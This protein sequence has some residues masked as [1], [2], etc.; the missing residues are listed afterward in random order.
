[1]DMIPM[2]FRTVVDNSCDLI[3]AFDEQIKCLYINR[4][5]EK[6]TGMQ[7]HDL[8]DKTLKE[9]G[10]PIHACTFLEEQI[11][12]AF[13]TGKDTEHEILMDFPIGFTHRKWLWCLIPE[14][15]SDGEILCVFLI[16]RD[17]TEKK[18]PIADSSL[19]TSR[20]YVLFENSMDMIFET[21]KNGAITY[22]SHH[23]QKYGFKEEELLSTNIFELFIPEDRDHASREYLRLQTSE[24]MATMTMRLRDKNGKL[25]WFECRCS[26]QE[27]ANSA[28]IGISGILKDITEHMEKE[29]VIRI[30]EAVSITA[31][32][33]LQIGVSSENFKE[34][35]EQLGR[36]TNVSRVYIFQNETEDDCNLLM[37]HKYEWV[38]RGIAPQIN[39][40]LLQ[41]L[42]YHLM[43]PRWEK[44]M[45]RRYHISGLIK[46]FPDEERR[47]LSDQ[48]IVS[49]AA[50]PIY[51][52][53]EWWGFI[54]F[55]DCEHEREW[56]LVEM[57][58]LWI[59]ADTIGAAILKQQ[60]ESEIS[61]SQKRMKTILEAV[62]TG[63]IIIDAGS[64]TIVDA[65]PMAVQLIGGEKVDIIGKTCHDFMCAAEK[66]K[67]P[68][69]DQKQIMDFSE[70]LLVTAK[71]ERVPILKNAVHIEL[72]GRQ[73][74]VES[75]LDISHLKETERAL[76]ESEEKF[77]TLFMNANDV[78]YIYDYMEDKIKEVNH[79]ASEMLGYSRVELLDMSP[80][81][82]NAP[83]Y[84]A[85]LPE[86][87]QELKKKGKTIYETIYL[88][89]AGKHIPMEII[90]R[91]IDYKGKKAIL[92]VARDI[93]ERKLAEEAYK[94]DVLLKEIHHRV[95]NNLQVIASLLSLQSRKFQNRDVIL[96][97]AESQNRIRSMAIAHEKLYMSKNL[98]N[99]DVAD[100]IKNLA[101]YLLC[102]YRTDT[103]KVN[104]EIDVDEIYLDIDKI[105][106][107]GLIVNELITN[108]LKH[109]FDSGRDGLVSLSLKSC[110]GSLVL[111]ISDNGSGI[112]ED[113]DVFNTSSLGLQLIIALIEQLKGK[114]KI[115][116]CA[117]TTFI[118]TFTDL[119]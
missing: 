41:K 111:T 17:I 52:G 42:P 97:F 80:R 29:Q 37:S 73:C 116:R 83:E 98:K 79:I 63:V 95:K 33:F 75:F 1:M 107:L 70:R 101:N 114:L 50:V 104:L 51:I 100:Y 78:I 65:N 20:S 13:L 113:V 40:P 102:F 27:D 119:G 72:D 35:L 22:V 68:L 2:D 45:R 61:K 18:L 81:D 67:C 19:Y 30:L 93:S 46:N 60:I 26:R 77:R 25:F 58:A 3:G 118:M 4:A 34:I 48:G 47:A 108:S 89:N 8:V 9:T 36:A 64:H 92:T 69:T 90:S 94:K 54:G 38:A 87:F 103:K 74:I 44:T 91:I 88:T 105:V 5:M 21:D 43:A 115:D 59:A 76:M 7:A 57:D 96:A 16:G 24:G 10:I 106:P 32:K 15:G 39:N 11:Q 53:R 6:A 117:G 84:T 23:I 71:G 112:P 85:L 62:Q 14:K 12:K 110:D 31:S 56:S 86:R 55:D 109:A 66:G 82:F 49:L 99:I 28:F